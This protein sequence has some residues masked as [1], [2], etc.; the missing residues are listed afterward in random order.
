MQRGPVRFP[1]MMLVGKLMGLA[2]GSG[3]MWVRAGS[4][5]LAVAASNGAH[6]VA[7]WHECH[8]CSAKRKTWHA[9]WAEEQC[10]F[11]LL[12][13]ASRCTLMTFEGANRL[14]LPPSC[15]ESAGAIERGRL[16]AA[17]QYPSQRRS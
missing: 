6:S 1:P 9:N 14:S 13:G 15:S 17:H 10:T 11:A 12:D 16:R 8:A 5:R 7:H 2:V 3:A 4:P